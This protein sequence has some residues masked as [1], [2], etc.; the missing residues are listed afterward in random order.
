M[1]IENEA[2]SSTRNRRQKR[3][4]ANRVVRENR[5]HSP[6]AGTHRVRSEN[7][8][9]SPALGAEP[10]RI[11]W[12]RLAKAVPV[13]LG[14]IALYLLAGAI[15][16]IAYIYAG[17]PIAGLFSCVVLI[18]AWYLL[19]TKFRSLGLFFGSLGLGLV[20]NLLCLLVVGIVYYLP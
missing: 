10:R 19:A 18:L 6:L 4:P 13:F 15:P 7:R 9:P 14:S 20:L 17:G 2:M 12:R 3:A 16:W 11:D 8:P 1:A 5:G